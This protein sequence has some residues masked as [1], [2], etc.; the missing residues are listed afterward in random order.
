M[1]CTNAMSGRSVGA[2]NYRWRCWVSSLYIN[3]ILSS[4]WSTT[5]NHWMQS[6]RSW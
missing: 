3:K 2:D 5:R 4:S 6:V 1:D